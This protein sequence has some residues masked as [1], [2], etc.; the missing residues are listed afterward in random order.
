MESLRSGIRQSRVLSLSYRPEDSVRIATN[1][2]TK[3]SEL[4]ASGARRPRPSD[5]STD[6][7]ID[8]SAGSRS[9]RSRTPVQDRSKTITPESIDRSASSAADGRII[10]PLD[11]AAADPCYWQ[12]TAGMLDG[13]SKSF[14]LPDRCPA[15][16]SHPIGIERPAMSSLPVAV[17]VTPGS[18]GNS[19]IQQQQ[20]RH[21]GHH[22]EYHHHHHH[23]HHRHHQLSS[24]HQ[25]QEPQQRPPLSSS[26]TSSSFSSTDHIML[27]PS[28]TAPSVITQ[29]A[30]S[31]VR[32]AATSST[33]RVHD[34][35]VLYL[36]VCLASSV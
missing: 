4:A 25:D 30:A 28:P 20:H 6:R 35:V 26:S 22:H 13:R 17:V 7:T 12:H 15:R 29:P 32:M 34:D 23:H 36:S 9:H 24:H 10:R 5:G 8:L 31:R 1:S 11:R 33:S 2:S 18:I 21:H 27:P 14:V 19:G 16:R 3:S